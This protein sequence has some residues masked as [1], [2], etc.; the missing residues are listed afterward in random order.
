M[1]ASAANGGGTKITDALAPV[2]STASLHRVEDR[3]ALVRRAALARRDA[4]D[5]RR[6]VGG[7]LLGVKR[8]FAAGQALDDQARRFIDQNR[9]TFDHE[10]TKAQTC[11]S[12]RDF[13]LRARVA[14]P[15][16]ARPSSPLRPC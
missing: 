6:A 1:T 2:F 10:V 14:Y 3:P 9:H 15:P 4:A 11:E 12:R 5:D 13:V 8:A 7:R 16:A